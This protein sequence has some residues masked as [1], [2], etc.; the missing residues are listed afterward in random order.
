MLLAFFWACSWGALGRTAAVLLACFWLVPCHASVIIQ[1][2]LVEV[3]LVEA[4]REHE[5]AE[6]G[7]DEDRRRA[8]EADRA[9]V[10]DARLAVLSGE[11]EH[12]EM[13]VVDMGGAVV[14]IVPAVDPA[15]G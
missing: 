9:R 13:Q 10:V 1:R 4:L 6:R 5:E 3:P 8:E 11:D 2:A 12:R 7:H 15:V 14:K